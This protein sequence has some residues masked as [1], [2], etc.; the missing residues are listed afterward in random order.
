MSDGITTTRLDDGERARMLADQLELTSFGLRQITLQPGQRNRIHRHREQEE[1]YL[2]L[3]G[4]LTIE[5]E[6][7]PVELGLRELARVP[8]QVRRRLANN[9]DEPVVVVAIGAAGTHQRADGEAF[10][11]WDDSEPKRPEDVPLPA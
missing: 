7:E 8:A 1:V 9:G 10:L 2:V 4:R 11:D 6:D 3:S 5:L